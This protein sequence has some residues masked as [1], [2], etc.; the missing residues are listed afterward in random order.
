MNIA[1]KWHKLPNPNFPIIFQAVFGRTENDK[2][3][4]SC[5]NNRELQV[6]MELLESLLITGIDGCK[7]EQT[8]IAIIS[9][10][11]QQC[12]R[13]KKQLRDKKWSD[14]E[15]GT[16]NSFQGREKHIVII[17]LV[18]SFTSLGFVDEAQVSEIFH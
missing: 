1:A 11:K 4:G 2:R 6:S 5:F 13:F 18:R 14:V 16:V 15:I 8:D 10:Y 12:E 3:S 17:S 9:P 7:V